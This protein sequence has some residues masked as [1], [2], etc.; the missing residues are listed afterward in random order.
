MIYTLFYMEMWPWKKCNRPIEIE[1]S[2]EIG[3]IRAIC[4]SSRNEYLVYLLIG[5]VPGG[6]FFLKRTIFPLKQEIQNLSTS[7][8]N[9]ILDGRYESLILNTGLIMQGKSRKINP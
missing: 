8:E 3:C 2:K 1:M 9:I 4:K 7:T 5:F 6:P